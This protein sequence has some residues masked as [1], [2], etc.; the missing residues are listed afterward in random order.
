MLSGDTSV[1]FVLTVA[2]TVALELHTRK[3][4]ACGRERRERSNKMGVYSIPTPARRS[5]PASSHRTC[6][7]VLRSGPTNGLDISQPVE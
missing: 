4:K 3:V 7:V 5:H 1:L 6:I 2:T